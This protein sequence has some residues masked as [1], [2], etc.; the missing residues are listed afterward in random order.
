MLKTGFKSFVYSFSVS[1]FAIVSV[2]KAF[3]CEKKSEP[4][5][6]D[7]RNKT[8]ALYLADT[9]PSYMPVK[10]IALNTM[11]KLPK[12]P[13]IARQ[14]QPPEIIVAS[15][16]EPLDI[17]L[18]FVENSGVIPND[19]AYQ[20]NK[21]ELAEVLYAPDK[22]LPMPEIKA[23]PVYEPEKNI[24]IKI[25]SAPVYIKK[26]E[27]TSEVK[28][29]E[30]PILDKRTQQN[31][32]DK[33]L[34]LARDENIGKIPLL[35][36]K[37][38]AGISKVR[39]DDPANLRHVAL[40]DTSVTI[41]SMKTAETGSAK[42]DEPPAKE[43][44]QMGDSPWVVAKST[45]SKNLFIKKTYAADAKDEVKD[46][47]P[48]QKDKKGVLL[49]SETAKNLIIPIP[50]EILKQED[51]TPQLAYPE[52]SEDKQKEINI[53]AK[54]KKAEKAK[55]DSKKAEDKDLK[56]ILTPID[57]PVDVVAPKSMQ[58]P[59]RKDKKDEA[60]QDAGQKNEGFMDTLNSIFNK[61]AKTASEAK[62]AVVEKAKSITRPKS[63][64]VAKS[65]P[66]TILPTEI[67][68][69]FQPN[70]AEISGQTLRWIQAFATKVAQTPS[71]ALE[72]RMDGTSSTK[73]QQ[74]RL[75]LLYNILTNKGVDYS[76][77]NTVF[78]NRDPNSFILRTIEIKNNNNKGVNS[79]KTNRYIQW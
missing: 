4:S 17:P 44:K 49:A 19:T 9:K 41:Q 33:S 74:K 59:V 22:P 75:N 66:V 1:L 7:I 38:N 73:L 77:I 14:E 52:T 54:I 40:A 45:G 24:E 58:T 16:L 43:W 64:K 21:I 5:D 53:N 10:K 8:I 69:S 11:E 50:E 65:R 47:I 20:E 56:N 3:F 23:E 36:T 26:A 12:K 68:L 72:I 79:Q 63:K 30:Q 39:L 32:Q 27:K 70:R 46:L 29:L 61:T 37:S 62:K 42:S 34:V 71:L 55:E 60:K 6:L 15:S 67:R 28:T 31:E 25:A 78:T 57:D 48:L 18:E 51:I 76:M 2:N 35:Q 13:D